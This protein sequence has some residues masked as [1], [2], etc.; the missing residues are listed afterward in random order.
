MFIKFLFIWIFLY[1]KLNNFEEIIFYEDGNKD[2]FN[3]FDNFNSV[4]WKRINV[5]NVPEQIFLIDNLLED[6]NDNK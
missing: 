1:N 6:S 3:I 5:M 4:N 2:N